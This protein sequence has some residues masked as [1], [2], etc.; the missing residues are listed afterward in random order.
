MAL[1]LVAGIR[2]DY[3]PAKMILTDIDQTLK[4]SPDVDVREAALV[5]AANYLALY[6]AGQISI[7]TA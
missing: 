4:S 3:T 1:E 6:L 5:A 2:F 7:A